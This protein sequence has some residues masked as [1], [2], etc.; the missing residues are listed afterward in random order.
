MSYEISD[1]SKMYDTY[2][3]AYPD[4]SVGYEMEGK[5]A[6]SAVLVQLDLFC[7]EKGIDFDELRD[8]GYHRLLAKSSECFAEGGHMI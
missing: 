6:L 4:K 3:I 7:A 1:A 2:A 5:L 8:L